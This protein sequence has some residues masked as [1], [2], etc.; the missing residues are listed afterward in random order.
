LERLAAVGFT[1]ASPAGTHLPG[2]GVKRETSE[3]TV[4]IDVENLYT[5]YGPMV[6]RRCRAMLRHEDEAA[7]PSCF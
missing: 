3:D 6:L 2:F 7:D 5:R 1:I 4:A